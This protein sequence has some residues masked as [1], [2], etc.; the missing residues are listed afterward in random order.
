MSIKESRR[1]EKKAKT[2]EKLTRKIP[3]KLL[4]HY[5]G[6][7]SLPSIY[8]QILHF[9][10]PSDSQQK[11]KNEDRKAKGRSQDCCVT[12]KTEVNLKILVSAHAQPTEAHIKL[13][14]EQKVATRTTCKWIFGKFSLYS[15]T[16]TRKWI[17]WLQNVFFSKNSQGRMG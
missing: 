16:V 12:F 1:H 5:T 8:N 14:L 10:N 7:P 9:Q 13:H 2:N 15:Q 11:K 6:I 17:D 3:K 4:F